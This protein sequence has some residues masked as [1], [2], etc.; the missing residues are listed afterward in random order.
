MMFSVLAIISLI[1]A[2]NGRPMLKQ[3]LS[4]DNDFDR[5]TDLFKNNQ[6]LTKPFEMVIAEP[7]CQNKTIRNN[8]CSGSCSSLYFPLNN[9]NKPYYSKCYVCKPDINHTYKTIVILNCEKTIN[10][11]RK[12]ILKEIPVKLIGKCSCGSC[13]R[14]TSTT[15]KG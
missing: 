5:L 1:L 14:I 9:T 10:G 8:Y 13:S 7:G 2:I 3:Q 11:V 4:N 6:C 15:N 12:K